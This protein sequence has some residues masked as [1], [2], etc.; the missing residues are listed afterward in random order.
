MAEDWLGELPYVQK[1]SRGSGLNKVICLKHSLVAAGWTMYR[2]TFSPVVVGWTTYPPYIQSSG[3]GLDKITAW[4][5]G[6][7]LGSKTTTAC[8]QHVSIYRAFSV[9]TLPT[10]TSTWQP[11]L[12]LKLRTSIPYIACVVQDGSGGLRCLSQIRNKSLGWPHPDSLAWN[13]H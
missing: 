8:K 10:A 1:W 9:N 5:S 13:I 3:R 12:N 4:P 2:L 7:G 6:N 11:S